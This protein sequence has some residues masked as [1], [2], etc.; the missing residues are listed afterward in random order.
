MRTVTDVGARVGG[1][2][3]GTQ[4]TPVHG[5]GVLEDM[6]GRCWQLPHTGC[7]LGWPIIVSP[8]PL[9]PLTP[10]LSF[11]SLHQVDTFKDGLL[12][13]NDHAGVGMMVARYGTRVP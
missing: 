13:S 6:Q 10:P 5:A 8:L 7:T 11:C 12:R 3:R 2:A 1:L 4:D 9:N